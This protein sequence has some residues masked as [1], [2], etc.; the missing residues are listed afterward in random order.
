MCDMLG[1]HMPEC[2]QRF[3]RLFGIVTV[4]IELGNAHLLLQDMVFALQHRLFSDGQMSD[5]HLSIHGVQLRHPTKNI[6]AIRE[7]AIDHIA[8]F[9]VSGFVVC[10]ARSPFSA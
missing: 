8:T 4:A 9:S 2:R 7:E 3:Q 1:L 10:M 5:F 6:P